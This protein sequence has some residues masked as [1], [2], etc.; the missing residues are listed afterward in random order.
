M[1]VKHVFPVELIRRMFEI[2]IVRRQTLHGPAL[3]SVLATQDWILLDKYAKR[4]KGGGA[5]GEDYLLLL[6]ICSF[7]VSTESRLLV[8]N[9]WKVRV[10]LC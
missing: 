2:L 6:L 8:L 1:E 4:D 7:W 9:E 3:D 5:A 10:R